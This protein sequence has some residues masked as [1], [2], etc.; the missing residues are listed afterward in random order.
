[1]PWK[2]IVPFAPVPGPD[3]GAGSWP[4]SSEAK[5]G[6]PVVIENKPGGDNIIAIQAYLSA[7]DDHVDVRSRPAASHCIR[8]TTPNCPTIRPTSFRLRACPTPSLPP[9]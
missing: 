5:W 8:S 4:K 6:Q 7:N 1:M 9:R 3:I 2:F